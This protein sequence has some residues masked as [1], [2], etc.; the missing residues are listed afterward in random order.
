L[1]A[2][3]ALSLVA[4][5]IVLP[6]YGIVGAAWVAASFAIANRGLFTPWLLSRVLHF[7]FLAY[8]RDIY[9]LPCAL[10]VSEILIAFWLK[11]RIGVGRNWPELIG[12]LS[13]IAAVFYASSYFVVVDKDHRTVMWRWVSGYVWP[14]RPVA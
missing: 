1:F 4:M 12:V 8:L 9:L 3:G 5:A 6:R 7:H 13:M 2:E 11:S 10:I 14:T